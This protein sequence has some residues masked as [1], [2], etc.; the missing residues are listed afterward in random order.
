MPWTAPPG[1]GA[2]VHI[3]NG[4]SLGERDR[5]WKAVRENAGKAGF[6]CILIP[7]GQWS[8]RTLHDAAPMLGHGTPDRR[9]RADYYR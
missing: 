5:R 2:T 9:P 7:L 6:D 3:W 4:Y 8:G 1:A